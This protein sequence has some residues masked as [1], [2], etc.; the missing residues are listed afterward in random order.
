MKFGDITQYT[1][2]QLLLNIALVIVF[3]L[4]L[5]ATMMEPGGIIDLLLSLLFMVVYSILLLGIQSV[6]N[7]VIL[8]YYQ[9]PRSQWSGVIY[10]TVIISTVFVLLGLA[11]EL[12]FVFSLGLISGFWDITYIVYSIFGLMIAGFIVMRKVRKL[13]QTFDNPDILDL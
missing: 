12:N 9:S 13:D 2:Q 1:I 4:L 6:I 11:D 3:N 7:L 8:R 5:M 10:S